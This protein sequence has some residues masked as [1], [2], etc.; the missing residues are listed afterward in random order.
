MVRQRHGGRSGTGDERGQRPVRH[1]PDVPDAVPAGRRMLV[2]GLLVAES[3]QRDLSGAV[4]TIGI[5]SR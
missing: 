2:I 3:G 4:L 5:H 1:P